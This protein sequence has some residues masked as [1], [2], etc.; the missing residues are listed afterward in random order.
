M[1]TSAFGGRQSTLNITVSAVD[2][3]VVRE[4]LVVDGQA[5][6]QV[7]TA[8][9]AGEAR[10]VE[11]MLPDGVQLSEFSPDHLAAKEPERGNWM[12]IPGMSTDARP[13]RITGRV[14]GWEN[15]TVP[16]APSRRSRCASAACATPT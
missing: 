2:G 7:H 6:G 10:F 15:V 11:R 3:S 13:W 16:P 12:N 9:P 1:S 4:A 14:M 5:G 8:I